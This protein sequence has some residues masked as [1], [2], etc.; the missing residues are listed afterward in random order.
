MYGALIP[1]QIGEKK[2]SGSDEESTATVACDELRTHSPKLW[3]YIMQQLKLSNGIDKV[4]SHSNLVPILNLLASSAKR[5]NFT[6]DT[7][8]QKTE[9]ENL[10]HNLIWILNSPI[11]TVRRLTAEC[12]FNIYNFEN[13]YDVLCNQDFE[14][15]NFL[16][17][18]LI[19]VNI[20]YKNYSSNSVHEEN[21]KQLGDQ[22]RKVF[23]SRNR[24]YVCKRLFEDIYIND[25]KLEDIEN[26]LLEMNRNVHFPGANDWAEAQI[27]KYVDKCS[28]N[29]IP[30]LLHILLQQSDYEK[31]CGLLFLKIKEHDCIPPEVLLEV[32]EILLSF[33]KK[34]CSCIIW[35]VLFEISLKTN[36]SNHLNLPELLKN[37]DKEESVYIL[38]YIIPLVARNIASADN[39]S[40]LSLTKIINKLSDFE[41]SDVDMRYI[42]AIANNE[43]A[44]EFDNLPDSIKVISIKCAIMLLQDEDEDIR[45][46]SVNF[47][48]RL[49]TQ[50]EV[51]QPYIC[52]NNILNTKFLYNIFSESQR[53]MQEL[54]KELSKILQSNHSIDEYNPFANDSK[55]IYLEP[56]VL[57]H[58]IL[59]LNNH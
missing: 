41:H 49:S 56:D 3:K 51:V 39:D 14:S 23:G 17:G 57:K 44:N 37:S 18:S 47:Y 6:Y 2:A 30:S 9:Y 45:N 54:S 19:L 11:H 48:A 34:Y 27:K 40:K 53:S 25:I 26:T 29:D 15:E 12:I 1:K 28:W 5:Y 24:S 31:Y 46:L 43:L 33:K 21:F 8:E 35:K 13:I 22:F 38:R 4:Q 10:L 42:A 52:L 58:L 7:V 16:H 59:N 50:N 55:N 36:L 20:C 32:V